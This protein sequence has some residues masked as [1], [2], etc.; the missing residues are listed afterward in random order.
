MPLPSLN[1]DQWKPESSCTNDCTKIPKWSKMCSDVQWWND[2]NSHWFYFLKFDKIPH[3]P[4]C[5]A[6]ASSW[7]LDSHSCICCISGDVDATC[8]ESD[9]D[10]HLVTGSS[11]C[12]CCGLCLAKVCSSS[13]SVAMSCLELADFDTSSMHAA[14][15]GYS[16]ETH[17]NKMNLQSNK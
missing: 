6:H 7:S 17:P 4:A 3:D 10:A 14:T 9:V 1:H 8:G 12:A 13:R 16:A 2:P 11:G 5:E 15:S